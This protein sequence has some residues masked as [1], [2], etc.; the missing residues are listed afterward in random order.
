MKKAYKCD[1]CG[2]SHDVF[3]AVEIPTPEMVLEIPD[4]EKEQRV[5]KIQESYIIDDQVYLLKGDVFIYVE[6]NKEPFFIWSVWASIL[7]E[8]FK[9]KA[10][11]LK[12][13][14]N[15]AFDGQLETKI[16]FYEM[17]KGLKVKVFINI[18]YDYA[19]IKIEEESQIRKDQTEKI[20]EERVL[21]IME[22]YYHP[23]E[24]YKKSE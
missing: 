8:D 11:A 17:T 18:N 19:V 23:K 15:V 7:L 6:N 10:E 3:K 14:E 21:K 24:E 2:E 20:T 1:I 13:G 4:S 9:T 16:P 22:M 12:K 5:K